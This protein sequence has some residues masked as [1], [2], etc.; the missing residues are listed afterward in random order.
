MRFGDLFVVD[1]REKAEKGKAVASAAPRGG[2]V[3]VFITPKSLLAFPTASFVVTF[4]GLFTRK[5]FPA[6]TTSV[7][8][9]VVSSCFVGFIIFVATISDP[10][11]KPRSWQDWFISVAVG[12]LNC[13]YL[14]ATSL[15]LLNEIK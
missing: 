14:A 11:V 12:A 13:V 7:W 4:L 3:G 10:A 1:T 2:A 9:P 6:L 5:L 8:V 15:G